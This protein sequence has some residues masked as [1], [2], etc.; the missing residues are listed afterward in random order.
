MKLY[1]ND[2]EITVTKD[3]Y[4]ADGFVLHIWANDDLKWQTRLEA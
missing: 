1:L 3:Y 2:F 4:W